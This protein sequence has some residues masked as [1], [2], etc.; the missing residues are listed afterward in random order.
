[1][2]MEAIEEV[3]RQDL[4]KVEVERVVKDEE[5]S[6]MST[7]MIAFHYFLAFL[8]RSDHT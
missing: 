4:L 1:M 3:G 6:S 7:V 2:C 5:L 8:K